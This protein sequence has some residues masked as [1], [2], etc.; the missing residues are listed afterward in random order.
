MLLAASCE[1]AVIDP[2]FLTTECSSSGVA[3]STGNGTVAK[4][5]TTKELARERCERHNFSYDHFR[6]RDVL[7][8]SIILLR[9]SARTVNCDCDHDARILAFEASKAGDAFARV[10]YF[11]RHGFILSIEFGIGFSCLIRGRTIR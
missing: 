9:L 3:F 4:S 2:V 6:R 5:T 10:S 11:K 1:R 7:V 8:S